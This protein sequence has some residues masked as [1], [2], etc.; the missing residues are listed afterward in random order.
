MSERLRSKKQR[1]ATTWPT[2]NS[3]RKLLHEA[4]QDPDPVRVTFVGPGEMASAERAEY[5]VAIIK[6]SHVV[7]CFEEW[8]HRNGLLSR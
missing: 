7:R 2:S 5:C 3:V 6:G 4:E 8:L 1:L